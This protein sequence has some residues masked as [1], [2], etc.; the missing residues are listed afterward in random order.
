MLDL[1]QGSAILPGHPDGLVPLF[2]KAALIHH[3]HTI[4]GAHVLIDQPMVHASHLGFVPDVITHE[5]WPTGDVTAS[6]LKGRG[7]D[8]LAFQGTELPD[9]R[10]KAML[11]G[12][13]LCETV[14]EGLMKTTQCVQKPFDIRTFEGKPGERQRLAVGPT[15]W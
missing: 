14:A 13:A 7:L 5:T 9:H 2:R 4:R 15:Y 6:N 11:A 1:A 8:R 3:H 10:A 12:F